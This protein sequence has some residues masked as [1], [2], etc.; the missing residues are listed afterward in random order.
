[1]SK[2]CVYKTTHPDGHFYIGK[3]TT[4]NIKYK[5]YKGSGV[6][7]RAASASTH[8]KDQWSTEIIETFDNEQDAYDRES[9]LVTVKELSNPYCLNMALGGRE[10]KSLTALTN[11]YTTT[12]PNQADSDMEPINYFEL[13]LETIDNNMVSSRI[14]AERF[15]KEHK[16]VL[17]A[18]RNLECSEEFIGNNFKPNDYLT[19]NGRT[20]TEFLLTRDGFTY[21]AMGFTGKSAAIWKENYI[22]AFNHLEHLA[23]NQ[24]S[25]VIEQPSIEQIINIHS[26]LSKKF[27]IPKKDTIRACALAVQEATNVNLHHLIAVV[28]K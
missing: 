20:T 15:D 23:H 11:N 17:L 28:N 27:R 13:A 4:D 7:I 5:G 18:I 2:Y 19:A 26:E 12:I 1:M 22:K 3:A 8:P 9:Q 16:S 10:G 21:L 14:V 6:K 25:T 24:V